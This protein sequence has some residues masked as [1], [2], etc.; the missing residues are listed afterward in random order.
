[1]DG[2]P[3]FVYVEGQDSIAE[4]REVKGAFSLKVHDDPDGIF[5]SRPGVI[6]LTEEKL[7]G[8]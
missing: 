6:I 7:N 3:Q 4:I 8:D 1:M 2:F 5:R